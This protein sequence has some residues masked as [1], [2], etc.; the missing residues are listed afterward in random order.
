MSNISFIEQI[1]LRRKEKGLSQS[2]LASIA[3]VSRNYISQIENGE[4]NVSLD[5]LHRICHGL[6][7]E[8][9]VGTRKYEAFQDSEND[10]VC[11]CPCSVCVARDGC[12]HDRFYPANR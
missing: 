6:E 10:G 2:A 12:N 11:K 5:V 9:I 3:T 8:L 7:I 4:A 1:V